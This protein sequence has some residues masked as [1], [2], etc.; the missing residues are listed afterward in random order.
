M[1]SAP[2]RR[3]FRFSLR[4]LF[5]VVTVGAVLSWLGWNFRAVRQRDDAIWL[6][7]SKGGQVD[8]VQPGSEKFA[9]PIIF[10]LFGDRQVEWLMA[11]KLDFTAEDCDRFMRLFPEA[12]I[13]R[14]EYAAPRKHH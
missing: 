3:W 2:K 6:I 5:V 7:E 1:T 4:T 11:P 10:R 12:K 8:F 9:A 14:T 13:L